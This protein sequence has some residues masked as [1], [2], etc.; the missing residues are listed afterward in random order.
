MYKNDYHNKFN[1]FNNNI[2]SNGSQKLYDLL[3]NKENVQC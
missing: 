1:N 3:L 2:D